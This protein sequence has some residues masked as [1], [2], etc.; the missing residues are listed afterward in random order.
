MLTTHFTMDPKLKGTFSSVDRL[1]VINNKNIN[2]P[3]FFATYNNSN[4]TYQDGLLAIRTHY[5]CI[6]AMCAINELSW[7]QKEPVIIVDDTKI[8][9][10]ANTIYCYLNSDEH[11]QERA[12]EILLHIENLK[13]SI[14]LNNPYLKFEGSARFFFH[15]STLALCLGACFL[16]V[17]ILAGI[18]TFG[19]ALAPTIALG[20]GLT[21]IGSIS[22]AFAFLNAET[23]CRLVFGK[24]LQE[25][26]QFA[27]SLM[28]YHQLE[29]TNDD[30]HSLIFQL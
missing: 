15:L 1:L 17:A 2:K 18:T 13:L 12:R 22:G 25:L 20:V 8:N 29:P 14:D 16:G 3:G 23:C 26:D 30:P 21:V 11:K 7:L 19:L 28:Q 6:Q 5:A 10:L 4:E 9:N 24:Q 27:D